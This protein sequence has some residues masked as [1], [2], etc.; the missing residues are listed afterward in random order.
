[1]ATGVALLLGLPFF[2]E[3]SFKLVV[4][5]LPSASTLLTQFLMG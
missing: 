4:L 3:I 2:T 5:K 1:M